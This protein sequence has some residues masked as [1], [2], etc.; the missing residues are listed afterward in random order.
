V[1]CDYNNRNMSLKLDQIVVQCQQLPLQWLLQ[2]MSCK[3]AI[4]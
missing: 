4:K 3:P 2:L 1:Q